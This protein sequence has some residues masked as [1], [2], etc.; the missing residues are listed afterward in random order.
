MADILSEFIHSSSMFCEDLYDWFFEL[1]ISVLL[2]FSLERLFCSFV[3]KVFLCLFILPNSLCVYFYILDIST[4]F[5]SL[6]RVP[7]VEYVLWGAV[8]QLPMVTLSRYSRPIPC[9]GCVPPL[10]VV[11]L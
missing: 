1:F 10:L 5:P 6:E 9:V 2:I 3:C 8:A 11:G 4:T 7:R